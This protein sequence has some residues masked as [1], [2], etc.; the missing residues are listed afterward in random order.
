VVNKVK[1]LELHLKLIT[2]QI[3]KGGHLKKQIE[4]N[5]KAHKKKGQQRRF[6]FCF[7][8]LK[9]RDKVTVH[10]KKRKV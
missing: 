3:E 4:K 7:L 5:K 9:S 1:L 8:Y 2:S 6:I 10:N